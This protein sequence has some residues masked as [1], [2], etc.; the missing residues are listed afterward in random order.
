MREAISAAVRGAS[1]DNAVSTFERKS[2]DTICSVLTQPVDARQQRHQ[3][4]R[5]EQPARDRDESDHALN[6]PLVP[7]GSS[8]FPLA[9]R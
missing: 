8:A 6:F 7:L 2:F 3:A 1:Y 9:P 5:A 4:Q